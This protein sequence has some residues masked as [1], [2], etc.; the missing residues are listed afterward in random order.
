MNNGDR[1]IIIDRLIGLRETGK[2]II[3]IINCS[4]D[5]EHKKMIKTFK[6][7]GFT[8]INE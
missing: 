2:Q 3:S 8:E 1:D 7:G 4:H 6:D 5:E